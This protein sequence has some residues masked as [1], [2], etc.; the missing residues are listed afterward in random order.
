M[1][2]RCTSV[3]RN[4]AKV[5]AHLKEAAVCKRASAMTSAVRQDKSVE[6]GPVVPSAAATF[7]AERG[8][9][10]AKS[11]V[12]DG[13]ASV[14][15][16]AVEPLD[17]CAATQQRPVVVIHFADRDGPVAGVGI[18]LVAATPERY[19]VNADAV[20]QE[21][22]FN[23]KA[24]N[25]Y[26]PGRSRPIPFER[27]IP[28]GWGYGHSHDEGFSMEEH[29]HPKELAKSNTRSDHLDPKEDFTYMEMR[30][31]RICGRPDRQPRPRTGFYRRELVQSVASFGWPLCFAIN[32]K[33]ART[34]HYST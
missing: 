8:H 21:S 31:S 17:R 28:Q 20:S 24:I 16:D 26:K 3:E 15:L 14:H 25:Q 33:P 18:K 5:H 12:K 10:A 32:C 1:L 4:A 19:A 27:M 29:L 9:T 22:H 30:F 2:Q 6:A 11:Q 13:V 23:N 7:A 34:R